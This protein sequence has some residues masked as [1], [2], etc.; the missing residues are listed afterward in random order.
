MRPQ[1]HTPLHVVPQ[2]RDT[3]R[4]TQD[5]ALPLVPIQQFVP[6]AFGRDV[7]RRTVT[8][9][10][11]LVV[12]FLDLE[13]LRLLPSQATKH[14]STAGGDG[15]HSRRRWKWPP[16]LLPALWVRGGVRVTLLGGATY[17]ASREKS[18]GL[19][20]GL[21]VRIVVRRRY[22]GRP[23]CALRAA[24]ARLSII[25]GRGP[26]PAQGR[27]SRDTLGGWGRRSSGVTGRTLPL[28]C[29]SLDS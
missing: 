3:A 22:G 24:D 8:E 5:T 29:L 9:T 15:G 4:Q 13:Y 18:A 27:E 7:Q 17:A 25:I 11:L 16:S 1:R 10:L 28:L 23:G 26:R 20:T 21:G 2:V 12:S 14:T 6:I 19:T